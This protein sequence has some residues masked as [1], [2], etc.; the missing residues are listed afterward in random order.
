MNC[1]AEYALA[2]QVALHR[3]DDEGGGRRPDIVRAEG[4]A[5]P[6]AV[7]VA[8]GVKL[9]IILREKII[10]ALAR[11]GADAPVTAVAFIRIVHKERLVRKDGDR[12]AVA[13]FQF[14]LEP[15]ELFG[16]FGFTGTDDEAVEADNAPVSEIFRPAVR[17][18]M[19]APAHQA[20]RIDG[21]VAFGKMTDVVIARKGEDTRGKFVEAGA[22]EQKV[23]LHV[24]TIDRQVAGVDDEIGL[25]LVD[26]GNER[27]PVAVEVRLDGAEVSVCNLN[28]PHGYAPSRVCLWGQR[29]SRAAHAP[30]ASCAASCRGF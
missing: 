4:V 1:S 24:S 6:G 2:G 25:L 18:D 27:F 21:L 30:G 10:E 17:A 29:F 14:I 16:F 15:L 8:A 11:G 3:A 22:A 28:D 13:V 26:P 7:Q 9:H 12:L 19:A 23:G 20:L 5:R